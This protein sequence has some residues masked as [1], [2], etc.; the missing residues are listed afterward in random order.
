MHLDGRSPLPSAHS[1]PR[2]YF[3]LARDVC[4]SYQRL[5]AS[6]GPEQREGYGKVWV[7]AGKVWVPA[8]AKADEARAAD[9]K[10]A[11]S[12]CL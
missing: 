9:L 3:P 10:E 1:A 5:R 7:P 4:G 11:D 12:G 6:H 2:A 8:R